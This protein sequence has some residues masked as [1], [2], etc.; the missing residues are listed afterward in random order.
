MTGGR[1]IDKAS[2]LNQVV[3]GIRKGGHSMKRT[4]SVK[5]RFVYQGSDGPVNFDVSFDVSDRVRS[6]QAI[7]RRTFHLG[8]VRTDGSPETYQVVLCAVHANSS[9][10]SSFALRSVRELRTGVPDKPTFPDVWSPDFL[11]TLTTLGLNRESYTA[12]VEECLGLL[13][14]GD[15]DLPPPAA[16]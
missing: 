8:F 2:P 4:D 13:G 7:E 3:S 9:G 15:D 11:H 10:G 1:V 6:R 5:G 16:A 14:S 12:L